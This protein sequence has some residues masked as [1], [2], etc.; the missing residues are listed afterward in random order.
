MSYIHPAPTIITFTNGTGTGIVPDT[1]TEIHVGRAESIVIMIDTTAAL[2]S[3]TDFDLNVHAE[4]NKVWTTVPYAEKNVGNAEIKTLNLSPG[5]ER[6][7]FRGDNNAGARADVT[8]TTK[9]RET[10]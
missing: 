10:R 6:I 5:I 7:R 4:I 8:V 9:I 3:C 1:D 2:N